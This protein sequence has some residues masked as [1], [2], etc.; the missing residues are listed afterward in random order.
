VRGAGRSG[1][2]AD[3]IRGP[4]P[5][6]STPTPKARTCQSGGL[7][8]ISGP[9]DVQRLYTSGVYGRVTGHGKL[10]NHDQERYD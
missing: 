7:K 4:C 3:P 8:A 9:Q 5:T 1:R 2:I 10:Q 6:A